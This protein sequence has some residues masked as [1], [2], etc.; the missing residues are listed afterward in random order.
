MSKRREGL[1]PEERALW[2]AYVRGVRPLASR[3]PAGRPAAAGAPSTKKG[4]GGRRAAT[5]ASDRSVAAARSSP[6]APSPAIESGRLR[7]IARRREPIDS[8]L[9]LHGL[10]REEA[11]RR[12]SRHLSAA[13]RRGARVILVITGKGGARVAPGA[14]PPAA[15]R[16]R[17]DFAPEG[18]VLR[19]L[20][21]LWLEGPELAPLVQA[22]DGAAPQDGG[23]GAFYVLLRRSR[24]RD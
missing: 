4:A 19:R 24:R 23:S 1:S 17:A 8:T 20:L 12:L 2:E 15:F 7:R 5:G 22:F 16:R 13:A 18:G 21:P 9:D 3:A 6:H 14:G 10:D 11:Y